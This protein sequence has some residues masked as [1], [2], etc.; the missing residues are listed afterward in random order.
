MV[1]VSKDQT[2]HFWDL[3]ERSLLLSL[4]LPGTPVKACFSRCTGLLAVAL[5]DGSVLV[6]ESSTRRLIR[7]FAD[8]QGGVTSL[9][10]N[11]SGRWLLVA[12]DQGDVRVYDVPNSRRGAGAGG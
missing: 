10:F 6:F 12:D 2:V 4:P 11:E 7:R 3:I 8:V 1:S 5:Q 9:V